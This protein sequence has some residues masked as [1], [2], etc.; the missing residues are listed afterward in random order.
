M[1]GTSKWS[2]GRP[3]GGF[4]TGGTSRDDFVDSP[5]VALGESRD[6]SSLRREPA[7]LW[8]NPYRGSTASGPSKVT[9]TRVSVLLLDGEEGAAGRWRRLALSDLEGGRWPR[10]G[11]V[12]MLVVPSRRPVA[13]RGVEKREEVVAG[14]TESGAGAPRRW[15][16][17]D[18]AQEEK[19][20]RT[21][22]RSR[23]MR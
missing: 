11:L 19:Q 18:V 6:V 1:L 7:F 4:Q 21:R 8:G 2:W 14:A 15:W 16:E 9:S 17:V 10:L 20:E 23:R 3:R 13:D 5:V 22:G 12:V